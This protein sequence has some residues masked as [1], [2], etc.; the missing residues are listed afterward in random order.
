[1]RLRTPSVLID[2]GNPYIISPL[3]QTKTFICAY[4]G[5]EV[6]QIA[7]VKA[8]LGKI[9]IWGTLPVSIPKTKFK[10][11]FGLTVN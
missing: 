1:M 8:I 2:F 11:G 7:V 4:D 10:L 5:V 9:P 6:S 3:P